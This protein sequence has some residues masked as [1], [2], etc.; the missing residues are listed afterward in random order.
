[1]KGSSTLNNMKSKQQDVLSL[2]RPWIMYCQ[3]CDMIE[4]DFHY[5]ASAHAVHLLLLHEEYG[6]EAFHSILYTPTTCAR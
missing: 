5:P 3:L 4:P 2:V 1:M 6:A